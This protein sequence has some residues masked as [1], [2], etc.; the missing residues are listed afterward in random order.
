M[1]G[2]AFGVFLE[3]PI[4]GVGFDNWGAFASTFYKPGELEHVYGGNPGM[5]YGRQAHNS[6]VQILAEQG[7]LGFSAF[8]W[9][10]ADF[11]RRN[12]FLRSPRAAHLWSQVGG[13]LNLR[14]V[15]M[16]LEVAMVGW[17]SAAALYSMGG[18][19]WIYTLL[20]LNLVLHTLTTTA[21]SRQKGRVPLHSRVTGPRAPSTAA[22]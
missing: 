16:G 6:Y 20:A 14:F 17:M 11:W 5:L 9:I 19:H 21:A 18:T 2:A 15:A 12:A 8:V 7:I 10:L 1:W 22:R 3:R 4:L 13:H